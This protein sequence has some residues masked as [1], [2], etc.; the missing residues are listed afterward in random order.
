M[1]TGLIDLHTHTNYS[2][3]ELSPEKLCDLAISSGIEILGITD[4]NTT[5]GVQ[6]LIESDYYYDNFRIIP[7]IEFDTDIDYGK[8]HILGY[9]IDIYNEEL[10]NLGKRTLKINLEKFRT[11]LEV[12][13]SEYAISFDDEEIDKLMYKK[14]QLGKMDAAL[15]LLSHGYVESNFESF[16]KYINPIV[17]S[18]NYSFKY[19]SY[20]EVITTIKKAGGVSSLAHPRS[21]KRNYIELDHLVRKLKSIG[22]N[23]IEVY[24]SSHSINEMNIYKN[25]ASKYNLYISGGSDYHGDIVKPD[26]FIGAGKD[27]LNIRSLSILNKLH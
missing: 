13:K 12:L 9:G 5:K 4:H 2:D 11:I 14:Y 6:T 15:L 1:N 26:V 24:H 20:E 7:G 10:Q 25:L 17:D 19:P 8:L 22:L 21:L 23:G 27:N 3:G 16:V 18:L